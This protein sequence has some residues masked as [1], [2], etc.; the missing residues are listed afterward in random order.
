MYIQNEQYQFILQNLRS[1]LA[2]PVELFSARM[3][4]YVGSCDFFHYKTSKK[5]SAT[6]TDFSSLLNQNSPMFD[7]L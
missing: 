5:Q 2:Q 4:G 3:Y 6:S 7:R 1:I